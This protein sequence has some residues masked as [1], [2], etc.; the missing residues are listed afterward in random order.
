MIYHKK[1]VIL[2]K[3]FLLGIIMGFTVLNYQGSKQKLNSF[4]FE[5]LSQYLPSNKAFL[6]IFS[7]S[8]AVSEMF[9]KSS[10][11]Y[12]NDS[13]L[14]A[15][16]IADAIL[17][18]PLSIENDFFVKFD[19]KYKY[20]FVQ[21]SKFFTNYITIEEKLINENKKIELINLYETFPTIWNNLVSPITQCATSVD[22]IK[23]T[24]EYCLFLSYYANS[25]FGIRQAAEIDAIIKTIHS[26]EHAYRNMLF[27]CLFYAM[28]ETVFSKDGHMAQPLNLMKD[29]KRLIKQRKK[30][31]Y[32]LFNKKYNEYI[33]LDSSKYPGKN[34]VY[35][36]DFSLLLDDYNL[37]DV[38]LIYADPP[39]T[40]MQYSRYYH[41][42]NVAARYDYPE[43]SYVQGKYTKGL[44]TEGRF[45][46]KLSQ[47]NS[48][49]EQIA[50]LI[51]FCAEKSINLAISFA[52]PQDTHKQATDRYVM[53]IDDILNIA[54]QNFDIEKIRLVTQSYNHSNQRNSTQKKVLEYLVLCGTPN[55][56]KFSYPE[57][58][59]NL[60]QI[61]PSK[62]N[63]MYNSHIYWSQKSFNVCDYLIQKL[64][65][66]GDIIFD[67][68]MGS[69]VTVLESIKR[70]I[71]RSAIGCDINDMPL[72][73]SKTLL[74][75]NKTDNSD[76]LISSFLNKIKTLSDYYQTFCPNCGGKGIISKV[77]F[78]KPQ[79]TVHDY[80]IT[81]INYRC[82]KCKQTEK[83]PDN[84]DYEN[85]S[86][87]ERLEYIH[88]TR[89]LP[90][91]KIAV[92]ENDSIRHIFT[93]R[94]LA[95]IDKILAIIAT[96]EPKEQVILNYILMSVL[97]LCKITDTHS[98]S[99][100]PL[101][102]P[103]ENCVEKNIVDLL[104]KKLMQFS[105]VVSFMQ[106]EYCDAHIV[107]KYSDLKK[108]SCLLLKKGS[109]FIQEEEIPN[110]GVDLIITDPPY[111]DQV[112][113]SEYLQL[114]KPFFNF[115]INFEDEV[116][117][118]TREGCSKN[119]DNYFELM[120]QV[121]AMCAQKLK[122][123][124]HLCL[125]FHDSN[126]S[127]WDKL[128]AIMEH[129]HFRFITQVH[130]DKSLTVKN[131]ISPKKSLNGDSILIFIKDDVTVIPNAKETIQEIERNV[132]TQ[133][134]AMINQYG[135][136]TTPQLY[137]NGLMEVLIQNGW[138]TKLSKKYK[139]I[140]DLLE[141]H[142]KWDPVNGYWTR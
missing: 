5:N 53:S 105:S 88:E 126:L 99:Q 121:F 3:K 39:Y 46:S 83:S 73:I 19:N 111:L 134:I 13:E 82:N 101:W 23:S 56:A 14:F 32:V 130:I 40:D 98:N 33:K 139:T 7:G 37:E 109:Q 1:C 36:K 71:N 66:E 52:Y 10:L 87:E 132:V 65:N 63:P 8:A 6:D 58:K 31:I 138:L 104:T 42:L 35:N 70:G 28:K 48:A 45:Q 62:N 114:Y 86:R 78:N 118:S 107:Q 41:L 140:I 12:A 30:S 25:Y 11:V 9:S 141:K 100:W 97:H 119:K 57:F 94:N 95:V 84:R 115:E 20:N 79:R 108:N 26:V 74:S 93:E 112:L 60:L 106:E 90:N 21:V 127:V 24:G 117:V 15:S 16:I 2:Q 85:I 103:K 38:G 123:N 54:K 44:Y 129:N 49:K 67:P 47:R 77:I 18:K 51:N 27:T 68:F 131:I 80:I 135:H 122:L 91:S 17:N 55:I 137:D 113:Y 29:Y 75:L 76:Y 89:M 4:I 110:N 22:T 43:P 96:Y 142:L 61:V 69:G 34:I 116:I 128:I 120:D 50:K 136:L 125:Y 59:T 102:I 133:A 72:F 64:S 92:G 124:H 81:K